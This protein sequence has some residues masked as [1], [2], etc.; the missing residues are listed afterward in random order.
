MCDLNAHGNTSVLRACLPL[1]LSVQNF[2]DIYFFNANIIFSL[3]I[4]TVVY[5]SCK[6]LSFRVTLSVTQR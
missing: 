4:S 5:K 1:H 3:F 2:G 6:N